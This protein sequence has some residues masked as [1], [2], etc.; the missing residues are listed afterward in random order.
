[1][2]LIT[3]G[4]GEARRPAL[5]ARAAKPEAVELGYTGTSI[6]G[7]WLRDAGEYNP[8]L[9][10]ITAFGVYEQMRRS[11]AQVA[12]T[13]MGM[14]LPIRS[15]EWTVVAP[16]QASAAEQE[17]ADLVRECLLEEIEF[18]AV[19][20]NALLCLDFGC[21]AHEEVWRIDGNRVRIAKLAP[22]LPVTFHRWIT[23]EGETLLAIE[24]YGMTNGVYA[25]ATIPMERLALFT[26]SQEGSNF[27]GRSLLRP[28][29][30]HW[31]VKSNLYKIDAIACERNGMGIPWARMGKDAKKEDRVLALGWL[32]KLCTHEKAAILVPPDW[33]WGLK[34]VEG[35]LRD[36][37][38][39]IAHHNMAIS[40]AG[41]AQFM[42]L[43]QSESGNRALGQ[44]MSDF[45]YLGLQ[46]TANKIARVLNLT[47]VRRLVDY[48]FAG[49]QRYP[50]LV[51][52][53]ILSLKFETLYKALKDLAGSGIVHADEDLEAHMRKQMGLPEA[54]ANSQP[55]RE[56]KTPTKS[57]AGAA[58]EERGDRVRLAEIEP[59]VVRPE[60]LVLRREPRGPERFMALGEI[61][62]ALDRGRDEIAAALRSA[63]PA[64]QAEAI[65][66]LMSVA[67]RRMHR[68]SVAA[69]QK[70][71]S[72][73][74]RV[75]G[76]VFE[77]GFDQVVNERA[78]QRSGAAP[79][80]AWQ[81]RAADTRRKGQGGDALGMYAD[82]I[83][84]EF[85]NTLTQRAANAALDW[86][87]RPGDLSKGEV[88]RKVEDELNGQ[89]DKWIDGVAAKGANEAFADGRGA[90][91][92]QYA[93]EVKGV[94]YSAL[95]DPN[96]CE[97]CRRA[98][99]VEGATPR[100]IPSVP[101]P[102]CDGGDKCRCVHV[103]V[104][105]DEAGAPPLAPV[106][107]PAAGGADRLAQELDAAPEGE[108]QASAELT[109]RVGGDA[110]FARFAAESGRD[111]AGQVRA[112]LEEMARTS[113]NTVLSVAVQ[114][115][116]ER[117]FG[118]LRA[119]WPQLRAAQYA[120]A[121]ALAEAHGR[122]LGLFLRAMYE[123]TQEW[124]AERGIKAATLFRG[125]K[126]RPAARGARDTQVILRSMT[127]FST[128]YEVADEYSNAEQGTLIA[129]TA[130]AERILST[131]ITGFGVQ[132][133]REVVLLAGRLDRGRVIGWR[134]A[135]E[136]PKGP[137]WLRGKTA[138]SERE[139]ERP[140]YPDDDPENADWAKEM[141]RR[142]RER[143]ERE[144]RE[145]EQKR[146]G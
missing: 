12:A 23:G 76:E 19:I 101:N 30:Q 52:Q 126:G 16:E 29:Y 36:P 115:A 127:S 38:E 34:G 42:M 80:S 14:K 67:V 40:M 62:G 24:Q 102:D 84:S 129:V 141:G 122:A 128:S 100:D 35:T 1:M 57:R 106:T 103:L 17:A 18:D 97:N 145:R 3:L 54:K 56:R 65:Q 121:A 64:I 10:G 20:E 28:M 53:R 69:D 124:L 143:R 46:A 142:I 90:G 83:V 134:T 37:K 130:P 47:T 33:D 138:M 32:E 70:L 119:S 136:R 92:E 117:E 51:P 107:E 131:F 81:I 104:F 93:D 89:S 27:A 58:A 140:V 120:E 79:P 22:R 25:S 88:I 71:A 61:V 59:V 66:K 139:E 116:V 146:E 109:R 99:G 91:Y 50:R 123:H 60:A 118:L 135:E 74:E 6:F 9:A 31:Y 77:F 87:R 4:L 5:P 112:L 8:A 110:A 44:T 98:D 72:E 55:A 108:M 105:A 68:V 86:T 132:D 82:A 26:L 75:L 73:I 85:T 15:A 13:L 49:M 7:G 2:S 48:N 113:S 144:K 11:D 94:Y 95:L 43:G 133:S 96:T 78:R 114:L 111:A 45:F 125:M 41:L 137:E 63:R 21:A 39:S